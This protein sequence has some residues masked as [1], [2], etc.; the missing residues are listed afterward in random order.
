MFL[1]LGFDSGLTSNQ[2]RSYRNKGVNQTQASMNISGVQNVSRELSQSNIQQTNMKPK[3][4]SEQLKV[5]RN[6][7]SIGSGL[8][9]SDILGEIIYKIQGINTTHILSDNMGQSFLKS[10][11]EVSDTVRKIVK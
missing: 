4:F 5:V 11:I 2:D 7:G 3:I 9:E 1:I 6:R 8:K 10:G